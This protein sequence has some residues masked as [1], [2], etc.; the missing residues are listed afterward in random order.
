[1]YALA[2]CGPTLKDRVRLAIAAPRAV[3]YSGARP[4]NGRA[5]SGAPDSSVRQDATP[6]DGGARPRQGRQQQRRRTLLDADAYAGSASSVK[7][8]IDADADVNERDKHGASPLHLAASQDA[9]G[10][11]VALIQ[12]GAEV[13]AADKYM[14]S[15]LHVA[16]ANDSK[17]A[18]REL[19][20]AGARLCTLRYVKASALF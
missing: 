5:L 11:V 16:A 14:D 4:V 1:M 10:A 9:A 12:A 17:A 18:A 15:P 3:A 2:N 13:N 20:R 6:A 8:L 7:S 19:I